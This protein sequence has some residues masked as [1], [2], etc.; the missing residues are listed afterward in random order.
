NDPPPVLVDAELAFLVEMCRRGTRRS[1]LRP[2]AVERCAAL[3]P[4][5][6]HEHF[7][8]CPVRT[9]CPHNALVFSVQ[10]TQVPFLTHNAELLDALL[11]FLRTRLPSEGDALLARVRLVIAERLRGQR[12]SLQ[13]VSRELA[14]SV[15]TVQ[16]ALTEHGTSFRALLDEV[17]RDQ[18]EKY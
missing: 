12:P 18:A 14:M 2:L 1:E 11:P 15:R 6:S 10:D 3:E 9:G 13:S 5:S 16:R 4:G 17:R 8:G 7:F